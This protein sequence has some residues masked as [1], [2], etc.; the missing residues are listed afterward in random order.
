MAVSARYAADVLN[1]I[2]CFAGVK[3][4]YLVRCLRSSSFSSKKW[5]EGIIGVWYAYQEERG[6]KH[7]VLIGV[8][9]IHG[10]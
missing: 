5:M 6:C 7:A 3:T 2:R 4:L 10:A 8:A 9:E 1:M